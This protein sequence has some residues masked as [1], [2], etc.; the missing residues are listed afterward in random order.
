VAGF[1]GAYGSITIQKHALHRT[2]DG[3]RILIMH[4]HELDTVVQNIRWLAFMGDIGYQFLLL[5]NPLVNST[6]R[7][8]GLGY[9]SL[10]AY[11]KKGVKDVVGFI[12]RFEESIVKYAA[13]YSVDGVMCGHIHTPAIRK[14]GGT[15]YFN[16]GDWVEN[17]SALVEHFDGRIELLTGLH[18]PPVDTTVPPE[19]EPLTLLADTGA[20]TRLQPL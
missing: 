1:L 16:S 7:L 4:G 3:R 17:C 18:A 14:M 10:S 20:E 6:R 8:F 15:E 13:R 5:L 9:W 2:A 12:G 11:V 19:S